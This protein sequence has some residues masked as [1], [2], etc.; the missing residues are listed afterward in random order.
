[1][2]QSFPIHRIHEIHISGG[3]W[4]NIA[5]KKIRRDTHD[6]AVPIEV[7]NLLRQTMPICKN[8]KYVVLEQMASSLTSH[9]NILDFQ[10]DFQDIHAIVSKHNQTSVSSTTNDFINKELLL[11][12][13][14]PYEDL[15]L[16]EQQ[17]TLASILENAKS[18]EHAKTL[19]ATSNLASSDWNCETWDEAMLQ[20]AIAIAQKWKHGW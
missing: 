4:Q 9:K 14:Y 15:Q 7:F 10:E 18:L 19:L 8:L 13:D 6:N 11:A 20:T 2:L 12:T 5:N 1:L 17:K 16:Y 3:S